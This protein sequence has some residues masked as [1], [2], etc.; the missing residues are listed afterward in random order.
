M[1]AL[2]SASGEVDTFLGRR[3]AVP[4]PVVTDMVVQLTVDIALYRLAS[5]NDVLTDE[6]RRR[7][8][9]AL[10]HL[11]RLGKGEAELNLP[12]DPPAEGEDPLP[13][14]PRPIVAGG[15]EKVWTRDK[16]RDL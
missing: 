7:Y 3:Y 14:S 9:D 11:I 2:R 4:L 1:R 13:T 15:P 5:T 8:E 16:M 12:A 6:H 10:A